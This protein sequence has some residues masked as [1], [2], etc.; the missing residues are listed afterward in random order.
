[1]YCISFPPFFW[2]IPFFIFI[3]YIKPGLKSYY[4]EFVQGQLILSHLVGSHGREDR[5]ERKIGW[6]IERKK[7]G[8]GYFISCISYFFFQAKLTSAL[9]LWGNGGLW[10]IWGRWAHAA[11][12]QK[13]ES[14]GNWEGDRDKKS[15]KGL[16]KKPG[17]HLA[18][19]WPCETASSCGSKLY[20]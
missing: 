2:F 7:W 3:S 19:S 18:S 20:R 4:S 6:D 15:Q 1:M 10:R 12:N 13:E 9:V 8:R 14:F 5:K 11:K 17:W 16:R